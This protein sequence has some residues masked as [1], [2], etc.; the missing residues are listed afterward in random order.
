[1]KPNI[2]LARDITE[3]VLRDFGERA[4]ILDDI[5]EDMMADI[6]DDLDGL[7]YEMLESNNV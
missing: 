1:M 5:D 3:A 7:I 6:K 2:Q 4:G